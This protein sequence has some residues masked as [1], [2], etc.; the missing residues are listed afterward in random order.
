MMQARKPF[1]RFATAIAPLLLL[2][3]SAAPARSQQVTFADLDKAL[4]EAHVVRQQ[5]VRRNGREFPVRN[6][7]ELQLVIGPGTKIQ[8]TWTPTTHSAGG[9][10]R[11]RS[12]TSSFTLE[13]SR[14]VGSQGGGKALYLFA[15]AT[16]TFMRTFKG[17]AFKR[18][19]AF[20]RGKDGLTCVAAESFAR[21]EGVGTIFLESWTDGAPVTIVSWKQL[22]STCRI[23]ADKPAA[24]P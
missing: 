22:S 14:D 9:T 17:G 6:E 21:E 18:T 3:S 4:I 11:G 20:F 23:T 5:V 12:G 1:C 10:K 2:L 16:L 15:E 8:Q 7:S 24:T 19:I 13:Q